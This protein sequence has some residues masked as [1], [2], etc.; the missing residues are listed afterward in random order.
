MNQRAGER[1]PPG[2][3]V[4]RG[5]GPRHQELSCVVFKMP[6]SDSVKLLESREST[7]VHVSPRAPRPLL[8]A[9]PGAS[10]VS[11]GSS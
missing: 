7:A 11:E 9:R 8:T 3:P 1:P 6:S 10:G 5:P 2:R 4:G